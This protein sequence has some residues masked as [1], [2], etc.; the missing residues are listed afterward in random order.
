MNPESVREVQLDNGFKALLLERRNL[1]VVATMLW[2]HV[3]SRDERSGETGLSHFLEH[4]MFKGTDRYRKGEIDQLTSKLGGSNNAFTDS[5]VTAYHFALAADRWEQALEIEANRMRGCALDP[6][7]FQAEKSVVLE[8]LAMGEDEPLRVVHHMAE[9]LAFQ[10]HPYHHPVIGWKEDLERLDVATMR[11]YYERNY[12]PN[13]SFLVAVGAF[14]VDRTARRIEELFGRLP[15]AHP[16]L[17]VL[18]E[19]DQKGERRAVVRFP[20]SV[21]RIAI[22]VRTCRM[23]EHDDFVLDVISNV[24][25]GGKTS[26]LYK[27]L[28]LEDRIA[29]GVSV[30]NETRHD[31]GLFWITAEIVEGKDPAKA[32]AAVRDELAKLVA[33]GATSA[34]LTRTRTLLRSA[35]LFDEET[36]M[37][38]ANKLGRFEA[39]CPQGWRML[40]KVTSTFAAIGNREL[41]EV[42][43]RYLQPDRFVVVW[44]L[45]EP[46]AKAKAARP[47]AK[48]ASGRRRA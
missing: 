4:M 24:L 16:R 5:D 3:G 21:A 38:L 43:G 39:L 26:R 13:R 46:V 41:L 23:G 19:P 48:A 37:D 18:Q 1:P 2:Y 47:R 22:A 44:S 36:A 17:P 28:V 10:V 8:E 15:A 40:P 20:G 25:G 35:F 45:P 42:A 29:T 30:H 12:G 11:S 6:N 14:D 32:E 33:R 27:R 31:P 9:S 7:E 34:E